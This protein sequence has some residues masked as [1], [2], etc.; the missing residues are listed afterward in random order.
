VP[1]D[2]PGTLATACVLFGQEIPNYPENTD[3]EP[4]CLDYD[5]RQIEVVVE[6]NEY[7]HRSDTI[8]QRIEELIAFY[9][10]KLQQEIC[11]DNNAYAD[12]AENVIPVHNFPDLT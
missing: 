11:D 2:K 4:K 3:H 6:R 9:P 5:R 7:Q 12:R 1:I 10:A 8:E